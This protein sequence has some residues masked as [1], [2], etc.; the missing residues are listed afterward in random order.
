MANSEFK[1]VR[2]IYGK[3][4]NAIAQYNHIPDGGMNEVLKSW[5]E[6]QEEREFSCATPSRLTQ[7]PKSAWL[8]FNNVP[9][10]N[11][12]GWGQK[13]RMMLG[14][15]LEDMFAMQLQDEGK[16]IYHWQD[17]PGQQVETLQSGEGDSLLRGV[18]D[19]ILKLDN[20]ITVSDAKTSR[21]DSFGYV[22]LGEEIW[23][24]WGWYKYRVQVNA[25]F[26]LCLDNAEELW[27]LGI[28]PPEQCHL[29]SYALDD[30]IVR[31]EYTWTPSVS[32]LEMV[33]YLT[34]RFNQAIRAEN[35]PQCTCQESFDQFEVKFCPYAVKA[36]NSKVGTSCCEVNY[37][38]GKE[39][40]K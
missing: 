22:P 15:Q 13:Q 27:K 9:R 11:D 14:R 29:F 19:Y 36:S 5:H 34:K 8:Q 3:G 21:S 17:H 35:A 23:K 25:Y 31:R 4:D 18:P 32:E 12:M 16:L 28:T 33:E 6:K 20:K 38:K 37:T 39:D 30:G 10:T 7:C 24:D 40:G 1:W 26:K 2:S